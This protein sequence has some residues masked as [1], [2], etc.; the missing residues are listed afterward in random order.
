M[1]AKLSPGKINRLR[2]QWEN[3]SRKGFQWLVNEQKLNVTRKALQFIANRDGWKKSEEVTSSEFIQKEEA[4]RKKGAKG[5]AATPEEEEIEQTVEAAQDRMIESFE[6]GKGLTVQEELF[7]REYSTHQNAT[8]AALSAGYGSTRRSAEVK[9]CKLWARPEIK[10]RVHELLSARA[11]R[12]GVDADTILRLWSTLAGYDANEMVEYRRV[13]CPHCWSAD[14]SHQMTPAE[15]YREKHAYDKQVLS[16]ILSNPKLQ[17]QLPEFPPYEGEW[18][19]ITK[20]P[21]P[22]CPNCRGE[23]VGE[24]FIHDT[25]KL[26][27][28]ARRAY[29]GVTIGKDGLNILMA[30]KEKAVENLAKAIGIFREKEE[31]KAVDGAASPQE[32]DEKYARIMAFSRERQARMMQERGIEDVA[33]AQVVETKAPEPAPAQEAKKE[34]A[35]G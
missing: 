31:A 28:A 26:S 20:P 15:Y 23:G 21:N 13:C 9:G 1:A 18:Y 27:A 3:D 34:G 6:V 25:R 10:A 2:Q 22:D 17:G 12:L 30:S 16:L 32:L 24:V 35:D 7:C 14:H 11:D 19:D 33:E 8:R 29:L 5:K 4:A